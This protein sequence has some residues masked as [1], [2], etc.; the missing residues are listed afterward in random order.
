ML[1]SSASINQ[2]VDGILLDETFVSDFQG[3]LKN[4]ICTRGLKMFHLNVRSLSGKISELRS[5]FF[6]FE[7][8]SSSININGNLA[9]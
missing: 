4:I 6:Y 2:G 1:S 3:K 5:V 9:Q 8:S 7:I